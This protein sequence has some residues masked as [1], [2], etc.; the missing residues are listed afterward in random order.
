MRTIEYLSPSS[1]SLW[2]ENRDEFYYR[3]LADERPPRMPQTQAMSIG[4]AFDAYA[5]NY[6]HTCLFGKDHDPRFDLTALIDAQVEP[7]HRDWATIH[8]KYA[9]EQ[10]KSAGCTADLMLELR[11]AQS[12]PRFEFDAKGVINGYR[13]GMETNIAGV[14]LL[15]KPD[16]HFVNHAGTTVI[17][18]FKVNGYC[19]AN[20]ISP[21]PGYMRCR[22]AGA[23]QHKMHK[24][25]QPMMHRGMMI[26]IAKYLEAQDKKWAQQL[27]IYAWLCG[28]PVGSD[29][30]VAIDQLACSPTVG[31][32]PSIRIA[33]HRT[34]VSA[35]FQWQ[36][37]NKAA[38][39]WETIHSD[40]LFRDLTKAQSK[41]KCESLDRRSRELRGEGTPE[42]NWFAQITRG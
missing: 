40:H 2:D 35:N 22:S 32:L 13:E 38:E 25:C 28:D 11:R 5:K 33:E 42:D 24:D 26:N 6:F 20:G 7:Q 34:R 39:I 3:Y 1:I 21:I 8:G 36:V 17:L 18:D 30:L 14:T 37:F 4:S 41:E 9:F 29:F 31:G 15:G 27:A 10:Y 12:D 16:V 19:S 23:T